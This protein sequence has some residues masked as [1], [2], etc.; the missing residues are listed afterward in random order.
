MPAVMRN[1]NESNVIIVGDN[2]YTEFVDYDPELD[3]DL[4]ISR[5]DPYMGVDMMLNGD[6]ILYECNRWTGET[7]LYERIGTWTWVY[8]DDFWGMYNTIHSINSGLVFYE[9][10]Q[11]GMCWIMLYPD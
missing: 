11:D 8:Q 3:D 9:C 6:T 7:Y 5:V 1:S 2:R 4:I 10:Y